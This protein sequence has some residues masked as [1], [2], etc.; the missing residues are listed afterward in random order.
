MACV[1]LALR[2][3]FQLGDQ[4]ERFIDGLLIR[5]PLK[6]TWATDR[7]RLNVLA[8]WLGAGSRLDCA[9]PMTG[10]D[11]IR[12]TRVVWVLSNDVGLGCFFFYACVHT[13]PHIYLVSNTTC[14]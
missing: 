13:E 3:D 5:A 4:L 10:C 14:T 11:V 12:S 1:A 7:I 6:R 2:V 9:A 8:S